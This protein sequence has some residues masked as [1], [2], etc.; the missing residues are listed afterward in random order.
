MVLV[1]SLS[2]SPTHPLSLSVAVL[3]E[4]INRLLTVSEATGSVVASA[5]SGAEIK[6]E[7]IAC[8]LC[9]IST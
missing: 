6:A 7:G 4:N 9:A 8:V 2:F 5:Q 1:T 3:C